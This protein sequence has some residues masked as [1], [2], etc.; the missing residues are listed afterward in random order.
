[1]ANSGA[2]GSSEA[3]RGMERY[4]FHGKA[5]QGKVMSG[6][7]C[8]GLVRVLGLGMASS[9]RARFGRGIAVLVRY[10]S[11]WSGTVRLGS[12]RSS[13]HVGVC[14]GEV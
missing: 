10:G 11:A 7:V 1:M 12:T 3:G 8:S 9:V 4:G 14:K 5:R 6:R 13:W 2:V